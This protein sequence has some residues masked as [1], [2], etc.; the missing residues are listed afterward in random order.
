MPDTVNTELE[1]VVPNKKHDVMDNNSMCSDKVEEIKDTPIKSEKETETDKQT[2]DDKTREAKP[3]SLTKPDPILKAFASVHTMKEALDLLE[4]S[5]DD[6]PRKSI[7][8]ESNIE[9]DIGVMQGNTHNVY[10]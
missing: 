10:L 4:V 9:T 8:V 6:K 1:D 5:D 3:M 7:A 2:S